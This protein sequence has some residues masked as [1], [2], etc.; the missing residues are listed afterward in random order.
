MKFG[1]CVGTDIEKMKLIKA[2]G[3]DYAESHC[4]EIAKRDKE[5]L[6][7]MKATGIPVAFYILAAASFNRYINSLA[8]LK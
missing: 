8:N 2:I 1:V 3:Y 7:A 6:D 5:H 4:Q